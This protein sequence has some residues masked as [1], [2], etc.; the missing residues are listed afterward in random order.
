VDEPLQDGR[1]TRCDDRRAWDIKLKDAK[2]HVVTV[3]II[4]NGDKGKGWMD[5]VQDGV[6]RRIYDF[7][8]G[9]PL[10]F[11]Q[12]SVTGDF[13]LVL[14]QEKWTKGEKRKTFHITGIFID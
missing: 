12:F 2:P 9:H 10:R 3:P 13:T 1:R 7:E 11:L 6:V 8:G 4:D 5:V 14:D